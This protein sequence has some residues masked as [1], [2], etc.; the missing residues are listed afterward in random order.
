MSLN[1]GICH[2]LRENLRKL[3][4][5]T[6]TRYNANNIKRVY[7]ELMKYYLLHFTLLCSDNLPIDKTLQSEFVRIAATCEVSFTRL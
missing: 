2:C 6:V 7:F 3:K 4:L 1:E 5:E